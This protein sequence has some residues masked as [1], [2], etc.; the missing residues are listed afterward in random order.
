MLKLVYCN[1]LRDIAEVVMTDLSRKRFKAI[2]G[3][4]HVT[5]ARKHCRCEEI[6]SLR[7]FSWC[8]E[9]SDSL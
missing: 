8:R 4:V 5:Y 1:S 3:A 2:K 9:I 7:F 6:S